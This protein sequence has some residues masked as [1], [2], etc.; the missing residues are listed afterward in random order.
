MCTSYK[1]VLLGHF[2]Q[3]MMK[4]LL[5]EKRE[6]A[7]GTLYHIISLFHF[8]T[9]NNTAKDYFLNI[10][11]FITVRYTGNVNSFSFSLVVVVKRHCSPSQ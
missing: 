7:R 10:W 1:T 11:D 9:F 2:F 5:S 3:E 8:K 4:M 6:N